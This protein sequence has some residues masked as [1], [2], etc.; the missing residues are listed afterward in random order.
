MRT[1]AAAAPKKPKK[2]LGIIAGVLA[3]IVVVAGAGF[4]T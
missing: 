3:A 2:K 4:W 1:R